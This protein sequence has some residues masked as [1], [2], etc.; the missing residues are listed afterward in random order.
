MIAFAV[1]LACCARRSEDFSPGTIRLRLGRRRRCFAMATVAS[2]VRPRLVARRTA[3]AHSG[4]Q[5]RVVDRILRDRGD[6]SRSRSRSRPART[7]DLLL[8]P[9]RRQAPLGARCAQR[10]RR[11]SVGRR[12]RL[13]D[14]SSPCRSPVALYRG[15]VDAGGLA[16]GLVRRLLR[17]TEQ[18]PHRQELRARA[19][20]RAAAARSR[21]GEAAA[22][23]VDLSRRG[24]SP[25]VR[26]SPR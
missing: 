9:M 6:R 23:A 7:R 14:P 15:I 21:C 2:F 25:S 16:M 20:V 22:R 4:R 5:L 24:R 1:A 17:S 26:A 19:A 13:R 8:R 18:R 12:R 11:A 10:D 3:R